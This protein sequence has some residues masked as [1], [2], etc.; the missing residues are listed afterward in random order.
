MK[1]IYSKDVNDLLLYTPMYEAY[2]L[3]YASIYFVTFP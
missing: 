1:N 3:S 2:F